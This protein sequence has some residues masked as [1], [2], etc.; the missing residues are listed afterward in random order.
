MKRIQQKAAWEEVSEDTAR[1]KASQVLRDAVAGL[2]ERKDEEEDMS[3]VQP[4]PTVSAPVSLDEQEQSSSR[5]RAIRPRPDFRPKQSAAATPTTHPHLA[6]L[7]NDIHL[8][9]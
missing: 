8:S 1:E 3:S 6:P 4:L 9:K 5:A 2:L 7:M